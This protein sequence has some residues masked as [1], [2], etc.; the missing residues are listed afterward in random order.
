MHFIVKH[1]FLFFLLTCNVGGAVCQKV[2]EKKHLYHFIKQ[3]NESVKFRVLDFNEKGIKRYEKDKMYHWY[4]SQ[5]IIA[6]QGYSSG[7]L[8]HGKYEAF[9][10][11]NQLSKRGQFKFGLKDGE[12]MYWNDMGKLLLIENWRSG[13]KHGSEIHFDLEGRKVKEIKYKGH[14]TTVISQ[15]SIVI[16]R[17]AVD[18]KT[19][20]ELDNQGKKVKKFSYKN[21]LL[22]GKMCLYKEKEVHIYRQGTLLKKRSNFLQLFKKLKSSKKVNEN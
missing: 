18:N 3:D 15:D 4:Q 13:V 12:W 20:I 21:G 7:L 22:H 6:T 8:L 1:F 11:N 5:K 19:V 2:D 17:G 16:Y 9:F 10:F 14:K